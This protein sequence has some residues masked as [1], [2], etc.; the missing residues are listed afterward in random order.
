MI[1]ENGFH[2]NKEDS[3]IFKNNHKE[4]AKIQARVIADYY[5]LKRKQIKLTE[6]SIE[7]K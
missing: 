2:T 1:V 3:L 4:L 6:N 5:N 7:F